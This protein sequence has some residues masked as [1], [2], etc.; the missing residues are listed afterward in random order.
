MD[1]RERNTD[2]YEALRATIQGAL[3]ELWT[4]LPCVVEDYNAIQ[5]TITAQPTIK[6][7]QRATDGTQTYVTMPLLQNVPVIFPRGGTGALTFPI[8]P[9]DEVLVIFANRCIDNWWQNGDVQL[10]AEWRMHDLSDGFAMP[11]PAS[12]PRKLA[13]VST[14]TTQLRSVD[15]ETYIEITPE[16]SINIVAPN[17][18]S[19]TGNFLL[20]GNLTING[21]IAM[22][23]NAVITGTVTAA[24]FIVPPPV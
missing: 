13:N 22:T 12:L 18:L 3:A 17:G 8:V 11:G 15:G 4:A 14:T 20:T 2:F 24:A 7:K 5:Q 19:I 1:Q 23:G 6:I 16:G 21:D 9:G 10:P